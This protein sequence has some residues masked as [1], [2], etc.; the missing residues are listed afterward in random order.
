LD[1]GQPLVLSGVFAHGGLFHAAFLANAAQPRWRAILT[2]ARGRVELLFPLGWQGP[3]FLTWRDDK[4][5]NH[6]EYFPTWDP[7]PALV[8][9]F[10]KMTCEQRVASPPDDRVTP[11]P[12]VL[13]TQYSVLSAPEHNPHKPRQPSWQDVIRCLELDDAARRSVAK[14]RAVALEFPEATE[15][16]GFKGTMTLVGCGLIWV[17]LLL[18]I[19]SAWWPWL[20][21]FILPVLTIFILLQ[22]LRWVARRRS[23]DG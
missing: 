18:L 17:I 15:E 14:R 11:R 5:E 10:E 7:W 1:P 4:G 8:T 23:E 9:V 21:W 12:L 16:A 3:A 13:S 2:G 22:G 20:G 19:L 6:E